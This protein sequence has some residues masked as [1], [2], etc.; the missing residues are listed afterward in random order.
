MVDPSFDDIY[1]LDNG[2][3]MAVAAFY[4]ISVLQDVNGMMVLCFKHPEQDKPVRFRLDDTHR[5]RL[6]SL[7]N[8]TQ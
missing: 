2:L 3:G 7:L 4:S 8:G 6:I 5:K 1:E